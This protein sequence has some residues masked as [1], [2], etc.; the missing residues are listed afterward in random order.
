MR[1]GR[2]PAGTTLAT[3]PDINLT[4]TLYT[5]IL[6]KV[7]RIDPFITGRNEVV[8]KVMFLHVCV[9]LF[10]GGGLR[11]GPSPGP[12]RE[13]PPPPGTWQGEPPPRDLAGRTPPDQA[14]HPPGPG[15]HLPHRE[16]DCSHTVN[17]R[18]VRILLECILVDLI[19][20]CV[21]R[22][23]FSHQCPVS[24]MKFVGCPNRNGDLKRCE[25]IVVHIGARHLIFIIVV[26]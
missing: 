22:I 16:E 25:S 5:L 7:T 4:D 12:G 18:P 15:R 8:A 3:R 11:A 17:E 19:I 20:T 10:T 6:G 26:S 9:V 13:N 1:R 2:V 23:N 24:G 14:R 21:I